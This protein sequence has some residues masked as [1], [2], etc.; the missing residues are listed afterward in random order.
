MY[1]ERKRQYQLALKCGR[2][3]TERLVPRRYKWLT[4]P[5]RKA[6]TK[7]TR[8]TYRRRRQLQVPLL[9]MTS[10]IPVKCASWHHDVL[11]WSRSRVDI[12]TFKQ[13]VLMQGQPSGTAVPTAITNKHGLL[14]VYI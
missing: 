14:Y 2:L 8:V 12:R 10:Q 1:D 4:V 5:R 3:A 11:P 13:H 6:T 7:Q 9:S